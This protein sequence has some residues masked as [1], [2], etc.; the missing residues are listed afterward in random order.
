MVLSTI[1]TA[2]RTHGKISIFP[3]TVSFLIY[4][5]WSKTQAEKARKAQN[6]NAEFNFE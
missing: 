1:I 4:Y 2:L 6:G 3:I 5:D